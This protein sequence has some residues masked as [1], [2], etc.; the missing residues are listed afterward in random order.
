MNC[1]ADPAA[2]KIL[3][4]LLDAGELNFYFTT[5]AQISLLASIQFVQNDDKLVQFDFADIR[6]KYYDDLWVSQ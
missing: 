4:F 5:S 3:S 6:N 2:P 1:N